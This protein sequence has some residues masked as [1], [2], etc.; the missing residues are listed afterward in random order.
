VLGVIL[1]VAVHPVDRCGEERAQ[2]E[3]KQ[4]PILDNDVGGQRKEIEADVLDVDWIVCA[5]GH[6]IEEPQKEIPVSYFSR[7]NQYS[8][9]ACTTCDN[10][11]PRQPMAHKPERIGQRCNAGALPRGG[12]LGPLPPGKTH[13]EQSVQPKYGA[14]RRQNGEKQHGFGANACQKNLQ[15]TDRGKPQPI[16]QDVACEPQKDQE[17][18]DDDGSNDDPHHGVSPWRPPFGSGDPDRHG[19]MIA[20]ARATHRLIRGR[21]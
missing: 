6:L 8:E 21:D 10:S 1:D 4:H 17:N 15:I 20:E 9:E 14:R 16:D 3:C 11:G 2:R 12:M 19:L 13:R 18:P 5:I 7:G